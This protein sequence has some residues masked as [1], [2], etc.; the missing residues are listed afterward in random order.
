MKCNEKAKT[1]W[2]DAWAQ[3]KR[4]KLAVVGMIGLI[5]ICN[6]CFYRSSYK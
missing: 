4:N 1:F 5:I 6:I 2:Q 3:L